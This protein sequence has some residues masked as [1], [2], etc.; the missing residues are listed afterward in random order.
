MIIIIVECIK[1][2]YVSSTGTRVVTHFQIIIKV[3]ENC[4]ACMLWVRQAFYYSS[5]PSKL[6]QVFVLQCTVNSL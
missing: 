2:H 1:E 4:I 5:T 3:Y 6:P